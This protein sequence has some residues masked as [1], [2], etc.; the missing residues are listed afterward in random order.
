VGLHPFQAGCLT[1][2]GAVNKFIGDHFLTKLRFHPGQIYNEKC[3]N[4]G[5]EKLNKTIF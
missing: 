3:K 2:P 1:A 4:V 5:K